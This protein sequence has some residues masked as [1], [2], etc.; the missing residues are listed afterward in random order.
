[1]FD[2]SSISYKRVLSEETP[3]ETKWVIKSCVVGAAG[4]RIVEFDVFAIANVVDRSQST[5]MCF[6]TL[7]VANR[8]VCELAKAK[9]IE[10]SKL[11]V[12]TEIRK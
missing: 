2:K 10:K 3:V 6:G 12:K 8:Y 1:M 11:W 9:S 7:L 5:S 4:G